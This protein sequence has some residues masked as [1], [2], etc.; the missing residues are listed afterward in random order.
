[1]HQ[2]FEKYR[3]KNRENMTINGQVHCCSLPHYENKVALEARDPDE[4]QFELDFYYQRELLH[5]SGSQFPVYIDIDI[6]I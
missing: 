6:D 5:T 1:M 2:A 4:F 3:E